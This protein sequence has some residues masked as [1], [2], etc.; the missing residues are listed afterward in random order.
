MNS[1]IR[2]LI[3]VLFIIAIIL[4]V[5]VTKFNASNAG[6][7][8]SYASPVDVKTVID[9]KCDNY[10]VF[11]STNNL[12]GVID[13]EDRI[14]VEPDWNTIEFITKDRIIVSTMVNKEIRYGI[15]DSH[16]NIIMPFVYTRF[17]HISDSVIVGY[18]NGTGN[19]VLFNM[20]GDVL[21]DEEWKDY[22][23]KNNLIY[24]S[25][26]KYT[27]IGDIENKKLDVI[28]M[29]INRPMLGE[30]L[31]VIVSGEKYKLN[32]DYDVYS[33]MTDTVIG[34]MEA[35]FVYESESE[36]SKTYQSYGQMKDYN[37]VSVSDAKIYVS[38]DENGISHYIYLIDAECRLKN[39]TDGAETKAVPYEF[40]AYLYKNNDG[41]LVLEKLMIKPE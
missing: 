30:N 33:E 35:A 8:K 14:I 38:N 9:V 26:S 10:S 41:K 34:N 2:L 12:Y 24:L 31:E 39:N 32:S 28:K 1:R 5:A 6:R 4:A 23:F 11:R 21:I 13:D 37:M 40:R 22:T 27:L 36:E 29:K 7:A 3:S 16:D 19:M 18:L 15:I 25:N 17:E 20:D